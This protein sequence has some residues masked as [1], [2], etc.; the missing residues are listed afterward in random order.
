M[1]G[2]RPLHT[3]PLPPA[4]LAAL[5]RAGYETADD[6]LTSTAEELSRDAR[7]SLLS[8]Q[9][10]LSATQGHKPPTFTQNVA[11][12][13]EASMKQYATGSAAIDRIL[14]GGMKCGSILEISGPPGVNFGSVT[15]LVTREFV[16]EG[17][18]VIFADMHNSI[19]AAQL[20]EHMHTND[21][22]M[23]PRDYRNLL[24]H[25]SLFTFEDILLFFH[26]L[27]SYLE[28][29]PKTGL[30]VLNSFSLSFHSLPPN[31]SYANRTVLHE[32]IRQ[33]LAQ[34]CATTGLS[35]VVITQLSTKLLNVD[36][37][38]A[39]F[40]TGSRAIMVPQPGIA[41]LPVGRLYRLMIVPRSRETG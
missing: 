25:T 11:E 4:T 34:T 24:L 36:G 6:L 35:V 3:L 31:M 29:N 20:L 39:S 17:Q 30:L 9:T 12:M 15:V 2:R 26:K 38:P 41:Y 19:T 27:P 16:K 7:I 22:T 18:G 37:T 14:E 32:R 13:T 33:A 23:L 40:D 10:V 28:S 1:S 21:D 8:S 5:T